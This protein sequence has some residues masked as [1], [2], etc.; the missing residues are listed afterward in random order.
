[1]RGGAERARTIYAYPCSRTNS[2]GLEFDDEYVVS[3]KVETHNSPSA[4]TPSAGPSPESWGS[5]ATPWDSAWPQAH[6]E[7]LRL[8]LADPF[9]ER[10]LDRARVRRLET[11]LAARIMV[12]V[13][14]GVNVGGTL[15]TRRRRESSF[16]DRQ[17]QAP[18]VRGPVGLLEKGERSPRPRRGLAGRLHRHGGRARGRDGI[19]GATFS[20]EALNRVP[21]PGRTDRRSHHPEEMSDA[22]VKEGA[23]RTCIIP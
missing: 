12:G 13:F 1:M 18:R 8:L 10:P 11:P 3:D 15:G 5:T 23:R 7:P 9:D 21:G 22:I 16:D 19:H 2:G 6:R 17:G 14:H 4:W 20:S